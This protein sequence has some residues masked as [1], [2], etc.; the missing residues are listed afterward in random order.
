[1]PDISLG[2]D[3]EWHTVRLSRS[4]QILELLV[5]GQVFGSQAPA[6]S[7]FFRLDVESVVFIGER[8]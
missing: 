1:M 6:D 5:D 8:R 2:E 7:G 3:G 4:G